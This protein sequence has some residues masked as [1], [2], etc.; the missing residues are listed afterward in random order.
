ME[1]Q[2]KRR[3]YIPVNIK[4]R[5]EIVDGIGKRELVQI[6][7]LTVSGAGIGLALFMAVENVALLVGVP[8]VSLVAGI[9]FLRK[10]NTNQN[11]V[12]KIRHMM[13]FN[14]SQKRYCYKYSNIYERETKT[15]D[16]KATA[17]QPQTDGK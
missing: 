5:K 16:E 11:I 3:L 14:K 6:G 15:R 4:K 17:R 10:D 9:L 7:S 2:E 12:D 13:S 8:G 1:M